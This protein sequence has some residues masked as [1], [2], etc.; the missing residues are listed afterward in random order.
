[1]DGAF[2]KEGYGLHNRR[3]TV[4]EG[5]ESEVDAGMAGPRHSIGTAGRASG[6]HDGC[7]GA[8]RAWCSAN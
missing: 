5:E 7:H 6:A 3:K 4:N 2:V 1:M 8:F